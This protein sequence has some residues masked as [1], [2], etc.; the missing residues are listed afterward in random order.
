MI[1]SR[2][3]TRQSEASGKAGG[4]PVEPLKSAGAAPG[5]FR[6]VGKLQIIRPALTGDT[7]NSIIKWLG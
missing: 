6:D 5:A 7:C 4:L 3:W 1:A 2:G